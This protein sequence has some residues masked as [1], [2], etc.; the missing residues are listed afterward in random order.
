MFIEQRPF[1]SFHTAVQRAEVT[2][3]F[4]TL[5]D[6]IVLESCSYAA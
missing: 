6:P 2:G 3:R 5:P 4:I 1:Q